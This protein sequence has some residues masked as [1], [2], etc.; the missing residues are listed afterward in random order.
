M[1]KVIDKEALSSDRIH[2]LKGKIYIPEGTAKGLFHVVHGMTEYIGRY[3]GFMRAMAEEGYIVFGYDHL[4]HGKTASND[5]ELGF[6]AHENGWQRL[7]DDVFVFG[8]TIKKAMGD[9][10]PFILM[11][12]S[13]GS[14]IVRLTAAQY[15]H[16]D[17]LIVM[18]TGGPNPA[19]GVG[20]KLA[21]SIKKRKGER[22]ISGFMYKMAFG[23][24]NKPFKDENDPYAWLSVNRENRD[25]YRVDKYCTFLFTVS[26]MEDLVRLN[27]GCNTKDWFADID[28]EKPI[29][30]VSGSMDPVGEY[31]K[32][33]TKVYDSLKAQ[34]ANVQ[35]KLYDGC[36]HEILNDDCRNE[37][38]AD[39]KRFCAS[40]KI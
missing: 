4:G 37:V 33:V 31:G 10:L 17:K 14:F 8:N 24:Y 26:A 21:R 7:V 36:R 38:V 13:M 29:L 34:G 35:M 11:G 22:H 1:I 12:H 23:A 20:I 40:G 25:K 16:Y 39:I 30:L 32:G 28:K 19:G 15:N 5:S 2:Q 18:G 9:D 3:D 27:V 6:I